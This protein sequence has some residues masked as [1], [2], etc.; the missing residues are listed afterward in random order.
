MLGCVHDTYATWSDS[1]GFVGLPRLIRIELRAPSAPS[2]SSRGGHL[3]L[4]KARRRSALGLQA[5]PDSARRAVYHKV[6]IPFVT[7][8]LVEL[9]S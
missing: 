9:V 5:F 8:V 4:S 1:A 3:D 2:R 7:R 6:M